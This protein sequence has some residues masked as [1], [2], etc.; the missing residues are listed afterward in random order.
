MA[1]RK[2]VLIIGGGPSGMAAAL[3]LREYGITDI[4][5]VDRNPE[6]GVI[7]NQCIHDGFGLL[8]FGEAFTGPEYASVYAKQIKEQKIAYKL[9][10][11]VLHLDK[12]KKAIVISPEGVQE[13]QAKA[14]I[15]AMGCRE[16]TRGVLAIPGTR[17][18]GIFTAGLA[19]RYINLHNTMVGKE[20]VILGSGDIGLIMA[21]RMTLEGAHVKAVV[22]RMPYANGLPRN[23]RQCLEDYDIPLF[24]SHTVTDIKGRERL[25]GITIQKTDQHQIPVPGTEWELSCDTLILSVGLIPENELSREAGVKIDPLTQGPLADAYFQT[26]V[27]GIF[28][29]GN[30]LHVHDLADHVSGEAERL[31]DAAALYLKNGGLAACR[32]EIF[33]GYGIAQVVP[34]KV[35]ADQEAVLSFRVKYP[36]QNIKLL[37]MQEG[38]VLMQKQYRQLIPAVMEQISIQKDLLLKKEGRLELLLQS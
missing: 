9:N 16:R 21:R 32:L 22:E 4:L 30:V 5:I 18:A 23:I 37:V 13:Y 29:A 27:P 35:C 2:D 26:S 14:V 3:R 10:A 25:E 8:N 7:L 38:T 20:A 1:V 19:Q 31:A 15:L 28:A 11:S 34:Q 12:D 17:P 33:A 36:A 6:L 24:L